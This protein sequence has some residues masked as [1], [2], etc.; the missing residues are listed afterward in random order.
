MPLLRG[1]GLWG[2]RGCTGEGWRQPPP[3]P[4]STSAQIL[5][6]YSLCVCVCVCVTPK[7]LDLMR[8]EVQL[9]A[10]RNQL[11][12]VCIIYSLAD[13]LTSTHTVC[14]GA[15]LSPRIVAKNG[16]DPFSATPLPKH[17]GRMKGAPLL[18]KGPSRTPPSIG[19]DEST[20]PA[21]ALC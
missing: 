10:P 19:R 20:L 5:T 2:M 16:A 18:R 4:V 21:L 14:V 3:P 11:N 1:R 7:Q 13:R 12:H 6:S 17:T 15:R 9:Q 8:N